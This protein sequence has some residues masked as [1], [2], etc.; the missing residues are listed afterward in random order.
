M[1]LIIRLN[2]VVTTCNFV[3]TECYA[4][5]HYFN[6]LLQRSPPTQSRASLSTAVAAQPLDVML[7]CTGIPMSASSP[8]AD[9]FPIDGAPF[10]FLRE[11]IDANGG[12]AA[13]QGLT[14]DDV[15]DR[16][17][18][19]KTQATKLSLFA[20]MKQAGDVSIQPAT[21]FVSHAWR[22]K[23]LDLVRAL[24]AFFEDKG[25]VVIIWL[26]LFS[27][28]QH[29]TFSKPPEWWEQTFV[30]AIGQMGQMVMVMT[31]W[32]NPI[33]LTRAW[34]LIEL[35]ACRS[36]GSRFGVAFPPAERARFLQQITERP[37]AFHDMLGKV[38]TA[39]SECS[40]DSDRERIFAAVRGLDGG[41]S[42]LD[43]SVLNTMTE[44]LE[45]QLEEEIAGAVASGQTDVECRM[46]NALAELFRNKGEYDRAL[47]L[48]E[49]CL[50]K[51]KRVLGEY[52]PDTLASLS[53][54]AILFRSKGEYDRALPL[55]EECLAQKKRV[56]GDDHPDTLR[57]LNGLA[58]FYKNK[59][60]YDQALPLYEECLAKRKRV[61]GD[62]HPDTLASLN[63]LAIL[64]YNKGEYDRALP[65][66]EEC[67]AK[68][69]LILGEDHPD[70][71]KSLNALA[72]LWNN[73]G[74]H[75]RALPLYEECL[76]KRKRVLGDDHP[77]TLASLN[78]LAVLFKH[79]V[80]YDR[81]LLLYEECLAKY[82]RVLGD[83]HPDTLRSLNGLAG[84][85]ESKGQYDRA[86][87]LYEECLAKRTRVLGSNHPSTKDSATNRDS[88][89]QKHQAS[90]R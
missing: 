71:L 31:P 51:R 65:L 80:Q 11:F 18:V 58:V 3:Y 1:S 69:K 82:K 4:L 33:S 73:K 84:L 35:Y 60:E 32:D 52:H 77:S 49:D 67:L 79:M 85:F 63:N 46:L 61:L 21:W 66:H 17:I 47:P 75:G 39:N 8:A 34:C 78:G 89:A 9:A 53:N 5:A 29:S 16:F 37:A 70:T 87:P 72:V 20:Q 74:E 88:C 64:L 50:V 43:R 76:A 36:S 12:D 14:T 48:Y 23:F 25:G 68:K 38:N 26:D 45:R 13:F 86:L 19:P 44:W 54:L 41:F 27:T 30:T 15:K 28:S 62:D 6:E 83:D 57:S 42:G 56:L 24:E 81:A 22:Y 55:Y 59:G 2:F 40:R 7:N 10:P 90:L